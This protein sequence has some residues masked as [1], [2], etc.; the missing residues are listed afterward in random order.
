MRR[1]LKFG[2]CQAVSGSPNWADVSPSCGRCLFRG[3]ADFVLR[4]EP[5]QL[6]YPPPICLA[7]ASTLRLPVAVPRNISQSNLAASSQCR[8]FSQTS[9]Q[10][11]GGR[12]VNF[13]PPSVAQP[14]FK[15]RTKDMKLTDLPNDIGLL[16]G[17]FVRPLWRDMPSIFQAP[18]DRLH[19]EWTWM[20]SFF[21]NYTRLV[22]SLSIYKLNA[23]SFHG[24]LLQYCKRENNLPLLLRDRRRYASKLQ[25]VMYSAFAE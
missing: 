8:S 21:S 2:C 13:R 24:S 20:K 6:T 19:M 23:Y 1:A 15:T 11:A 18:R 3:S 10:W 5:L 17:T 16:P 12:A 25:E 7:M 14:S 22:Y 9:Q 4:Q